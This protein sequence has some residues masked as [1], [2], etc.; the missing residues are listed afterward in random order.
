MTM[1][2]TFESIQL[3]ALV[4]RV[5]ALHA[6][7]CRLVQI[8]AT[9]LADDVE[10]TYSF[11]SHG[12]LLNLRLLI[13]ARARIPSISGVYW[14]AFIYENE[15]HDLFDLAIEDMAVDFQGHFYQTAVKFP[16]A[17]TPA[18]GAVSAAKVASAVK[19]LPGGS[20]A[21]S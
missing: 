20:P 5:Q 8:G 10:L 14:C 6:Q 17:R 18:N 4:D 2:F 13:P 12:Q 19:P 3:G 21:L 15:L 9:R 1:P 16:F 11:D 7:G